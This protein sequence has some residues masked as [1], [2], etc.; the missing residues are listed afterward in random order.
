[1]Q[2]AGVAHGNMVPPGGGRL[3]ATALGIVLTPSRTHVPLR[4]MRALA[5]ESDV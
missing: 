4:G 2:D 1:V 3:K 5:I